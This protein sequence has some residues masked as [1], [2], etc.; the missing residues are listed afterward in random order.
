MT[1]LNVS[2]L[3]STSLVFDYVENLNGTWFYLKY[4]S[5]SESE[6]KLERIAIFTL[7]SLSYVEL[8]NKM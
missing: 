2:G 4:F 6:C 7:K 3:L 1:F 5:L 8:L